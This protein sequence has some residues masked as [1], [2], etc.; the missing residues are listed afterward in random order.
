MR[1]GDSNAKAL[2]SPENRERSGIHYLGTCL[3]LAWYYCL[4]F[5]PNAFPTVP[6]TYDAITFSW[7]STLALTGFAFLVTPFIFTKQHIYEKPVIM[8]VVA[9]LTCITT[10]LFGIFDGILNNFVFAYILFPLLFAFGNAIMWVAWGEFH[11]RRKSSFSFQK[12]SLAFGAVMLASMTICAILPHYAVNFFVAALPV[13]SALFYHYE[14]KELGDAGFPTLLPKA[15]RTKTTKAT[16]YI[17]IVIFVTCTA[18]YFNIAI[19]PIDLLL[20]SGISYV[21]GITGSA[22][23]CLLLS[24]FQKITGKEIASY[25]LLPWVVVACC[26]ALGL[27]VNADTTLFNLSFIITVTLAGIFELFLISYFGS[28]ANKG[29]LAPI[30]AF[31]VSSAVVRLGFFVGD[32]WAIVYENNPFLHESFTQSTSIFLLCLLAASLIPLMRQESAIIQ[33]TKAPVGASEVEEVCDAAIEEF[34]LSKREGEILKY[35][36][37]GYTIDNISKKLVISPYTTQTHVRHIYSKM[38]VH[39]RSELLDYI[40]MHRS[41]A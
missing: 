28:L 21:V 4:W 39:K 11:A 19:I 34:S 3:I 13:A 8:R 31:G 17:S 26:A 10:L 40:N 5:S 7:L 32:G 2:L 20:P 29:H 6:I 36:A 22:I 41:D 38:N 18:C 9:V 24:F 14:N 33:L 12:F 1:S 25:R 30:M 23:I 27:F 16:V 37:R 15:T 35:I